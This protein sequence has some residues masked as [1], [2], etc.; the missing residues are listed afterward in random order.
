VGRASLTVNHH[1]GYIAV[2]RAG[3]TIRILLLALLG[4][5]SLSSLEA[6]DEPSSIR[7]GMWTLNQGRSVLP[8]PRRQILWV[9]ESSTDTF[10]FVIAHVETDG[11]ISIVSWVGRYDGVERPVAGADEALGVTRGEAG[12]FR[13][14]G[15]RGSGESFEER[16]MQNY[17]RSVLRCEGLV[18]SKD[19]SRTTDHYVED[20][21]WRNKNPIAQ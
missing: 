18:H 5:L 19:S 7:E 20:Y 6:A 10:V 14:A 3:W 11:G 9:V 8:T 21:D 12:T 13:I 2:A 16:C 1:R 4:T 17:S 15:H